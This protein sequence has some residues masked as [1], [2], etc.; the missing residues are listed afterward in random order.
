MNGDCLQW[1][2]AG[3]Q[4]LKLQLAGSTSQAP[5]FVSIT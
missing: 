4:D 2:L 1:Y 3:L 5:R